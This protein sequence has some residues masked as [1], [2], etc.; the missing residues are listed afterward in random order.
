MSE[1]SKKVYEHQKKTSKLVRLYNDT[2]EL[3]DAYQEE[4]QVSSRNAA[5]KRLLVDR[6]LEKENG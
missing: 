6:L 4:K 1:H 2:L 3:L 5:I